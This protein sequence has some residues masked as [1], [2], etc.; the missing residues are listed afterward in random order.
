MSEKNLEI[1]SGLIEEAHRRIQKDFENINPV[2]GVNRGMRSVG[3]PADVITID[4]LKTGKRIIL[5]INDQLPELLQYQYSY[6]ADDPA[7]EFI[8]LPFKELTD[9]VLYDWMK[10]YFNNDY[11]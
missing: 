4:C 6:K 10:D 7:E 3:I 1:L 11:N 9:Q 5:V 2:I 8:D